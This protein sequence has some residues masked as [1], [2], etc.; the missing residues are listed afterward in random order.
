[1]FKK[2]LL[3]VVLALSFFAA[4]GADASQPPPTCD[5]CPWVN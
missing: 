5:P 2:T 1:M 4:I 3:A